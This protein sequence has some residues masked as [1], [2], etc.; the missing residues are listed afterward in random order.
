MTPDK[1]KRLEELNLEWTAIQYC[2]DHGYLNE[3]TLQEG[4]DRQAAIKAEIAI[5]EASK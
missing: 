3:K 4:I 5:L 2:R 1:A